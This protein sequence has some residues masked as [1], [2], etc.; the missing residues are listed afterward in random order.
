MFF[1][2]ASQFRRDREGATFDVEKF[3]GETK[4]DEMPKIEDGSSL[5]EFEEFLVL[6]SGAVVKAGGM[7]SL[8]VVCDRPGS[9]VTW[10]F[11]VVEEGTDV[12]F[13]LRWKSSSS[14]K[15]LVEPERVAGLSG[16]FDVTEPATLEFE[17]DNTY[18]WLTEKTLDYHV[19]ILEP[20]TEDKKKI[21]YILE[22][23]L[24]NVV[25]IDPLIGI[26]KFCFLK[27]LKTYNQV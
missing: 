22:V 10:K 18:S 2:E 5:D 21:R 8:P 19:S 23:E 11:V 14:I 15:I 17:W 7:F 16:T 4:G 20:F 24:E 25:L 13:S 12:A 26:A 3:L 9:R 1:R 6:N 27:P